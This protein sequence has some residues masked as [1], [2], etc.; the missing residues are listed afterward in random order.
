MKLGTL[1]PPALTLI[2]DWR[3]TR[4]TAPASPSAT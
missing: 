2:T 3:D 4:A 1:P